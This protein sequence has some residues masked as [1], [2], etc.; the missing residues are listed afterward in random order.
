MS[1]YNYPFP[2]VPLPSTSTSRRVRQRQQFTSRNTVLLTNS[3][4]T[5]LNQLHGRLNSS[6]P[7][8]DI[9]LAN[10][11]NIHNAYDPLPNSKPARQQHQ[12]QPETINRCHQRVYQAC[13]RFRRHSSGDGS[14]VINDSSIF[15]DLHRS[16]N[17]KQLHSTLS[18]TPAPVRIIKSSDVSLPSIAGTAK[19]FDIL[20]PSL[21]QLYSKPKTLLQPPCVRLHHRPAFMCSPSEYVKLI[22]RMMDR[23]MIAFTKKPKA[24]NGL[25][26]VDKDN[27]A[28][29]RLIIDARP[30]NSMF[31]PSLHV[32]LPTPDLIASAS[33]PAGAQLFAAKVDLDNF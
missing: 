8:P 23:G 9:Y 4:L 31:M 7:D 2:M 11:Y 3:V 29:I 25:F 15:N 13:S 16:Y 33:V 21:V 17:D 22:Q 10:L 6:D 27:G 28:S 32:Q 26:G 1:S 30:V 14:D 20:P 18:S 19:L 12:L 24:V 5:A